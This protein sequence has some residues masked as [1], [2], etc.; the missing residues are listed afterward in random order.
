MMQGR[1][2]VEQVQWPIFGVI[3]LTAGVSLLVSARR[4]RLL[5]LAR[6]RSKRRFYTFLG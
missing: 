6:E 1:L 3:L 5:R 4:R 2:M